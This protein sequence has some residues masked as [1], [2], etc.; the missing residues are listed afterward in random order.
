MFMSGKGG[1][2]STF[3]AAIV[4]DFLLRNEIKY[5][6][7]DL[8]ALNM[9]LANIPSLGARKPGLAFTRWGMQYLDEQ[10]L[11]ETFRRI[12]D[13]EDTIIV[14]VASNSYYQVN[15]WLLTHDVIRILHEQGVE[16]TI[17][18]VVR[19][20]AS[21]YDC[22]K[23]L[24]QTIRHY[25]TARFAVWLNEV[26]GAISHAGKDFTDLKIYLD[27]KERIER[28][29]VIAQE[30]SD[31]IK[32][33]IQRMKSRQRMPED[34]IRAPETGI[35]NKLRYRQIQVANDALARRAIIQRT[36]HDTRK[37]SR[38]SKSSENETR[39]DS[40]AK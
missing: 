30:K 21:L 16:T 37:K 11:A 8:D 9:G 23:T 17:H 25:P 39:P 34:A 18:S 19:G 7:Y 28:I 4:C 24:S 2:G 3:A 31:L 22:L 20:G 40:R 32:N 13:S 38:S 33:D 6:A 35:I 29:L 10:V 14:D 12:R 36:K 1:A 15:T 26:E 27:H 5:Q